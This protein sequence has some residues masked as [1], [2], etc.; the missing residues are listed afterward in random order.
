[1]HGCGPAVVPD[2]SAD[3]LTWRNDESE[4]N[5]MNGDAIEKKKK[6]KKEVA[7]QT[8]KVSGAR[9]RT[10]YA[11]GPICLGL[12]LRPGKTWDVKT[13]RFKWRIFKHKEPRV[14]TAPI[15]VT[16]NSGT[17][18]ATTASATSWNRLTFQVYIY[19][20]ELNNRTPFPGV[21]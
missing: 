1:M 18:L 10:C 5:G 16:Q 6:K 7:D 21:S 17:C 15:T 20:Q 9:T 14:I 3:L 2:P 19:V 12:S 8:N 4:S 11:K 13:Q